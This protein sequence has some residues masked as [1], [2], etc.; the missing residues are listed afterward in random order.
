FPLVIRSMPAPFPSPKAHD[1]SNRTKS[2]AYRVFLLVA[3]IPW[4]KPA[5][6]STQERLI[7]KN[8]HGPLGS[9]KL[10][11]PNGEV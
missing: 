3:R 10:P 4:Q 9:K 6:S 11:F 2:L 1:N 8:L 5:D 7:I